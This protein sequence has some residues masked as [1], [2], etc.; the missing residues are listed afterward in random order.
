MNC[1]MFKMARIE[2]DQ[3]YLTSDIAANITQWF[4]IS[5]IWTMNDMHYRLLVEAMVMFIWAMP[6]ISTVNHNSLKIAETTVW[7]QEPQL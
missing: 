3:L 2:S 5:L 1:Y 6:R 7:S 4:I